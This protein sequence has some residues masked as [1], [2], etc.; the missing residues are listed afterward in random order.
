LR[1]R[2]NAENERKRRLRKEIC[3]ALSCTTFAGQDRFRKADCR[4]Q[5]A[6][7]SVL[8]ARQRLKVRRSFFFNLE[9]A[10]DEL[11]QNRL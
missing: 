11:F 7:Y 6:R 10:L 4:A 2:K 5:V 1:L 8:I 9:A 3:P